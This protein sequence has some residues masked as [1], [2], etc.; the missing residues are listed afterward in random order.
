M[1][2]EKRRHR[3]PLIQ[4]T[5]PFRYAWLNLFGMSVAGWMMLGLGACATL[6]SLP[7]V[8]LSDPAWTVWRSQAL[9]KPESGRPALAGDL[10]AARHSNHDVLV[11]FSKSA[12]P[13]FT[14]QTAGEYW[15]IDFVER[16]R[17]YSGRGEPPK[18]FIW[19]RLPSL[20]GGGAVPR[21][22]K[23][24]GAAGGEWSILNQRTGESI[25]VVFDQ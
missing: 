1:A 19:F 21:E 22:W 12:L 4:E 23:M 24:T 9:W 13:I 5:G 10:I 18:R 2:E 20:F 16:A 7:E 14:A 3:F 6:H 8:D 15:R 17:F 11:S 25:R